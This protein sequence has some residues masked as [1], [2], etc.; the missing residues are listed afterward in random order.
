MTTKRIMTEEAK[1]ALLGMLP[2]SGNGFPY[3]PEIYPEEHKEYAP[4]VYIRMWS[5]D[6]RKAH[7]SDLQATDIHEVILK[8]SHLAI[9]DIKNVFDLSTGEEVDVKKDN[10]KIDFD[11]Y[12]K[13]PVSLIYAIYK[14]VNEISSL[15]V[16]KAVDEKES[17]G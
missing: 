7:D 4:T 9:L 1:K 17:L 5:I 6:D 10:G 16:T 14:K 13:Q 3:I 2:I 12:K 11:W 15:M 8:Y